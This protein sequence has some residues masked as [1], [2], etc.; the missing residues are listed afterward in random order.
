MVAIPDKS[1]RAPGAPRL[2]LWLIVGPGIWGLQAAANYILA[3]HACTSASVPLTIHLISLTGIAANAGAALIA[4]RRYKSAS[5]KNQANE[6][7]DMPPERWLPAAG[8]AMSIAFAML[9]FLQGIPSLI[10]EHCQ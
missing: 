4:W 5:E 10:L 9:I 2:W 3:P 8:C 7:D 6:I 1:V